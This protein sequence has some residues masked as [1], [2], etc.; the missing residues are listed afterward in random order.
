MYTCKK[1]LFTFLFLI[2][3]T[4]SYAGTV[5]MATISADATAAG[6]NSNYSIIANALNGNIEGS[7]DSGASVS[8]IKADSVFEINMGDDANPRLRDS[9]LLNITVDTI[10]GGAVSSQGT[11]VE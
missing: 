10:S 5:T 8:N 2:Y 11:V 6:F 7:T 9:E 1:L 3:S 4:A